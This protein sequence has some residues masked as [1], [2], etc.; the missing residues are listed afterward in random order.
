[1][2]D[3][4]DYDWGDYDEPPAQE[5]DDTCEECGKELD[6]GALMRIEER[7]SYY[8]YADHVCTD[9]WYSGG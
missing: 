6:E 4:S 5:S 7:S 1:M 9:C 2:I 8:G 3:E